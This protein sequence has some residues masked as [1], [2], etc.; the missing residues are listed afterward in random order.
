MTKTVPLNSLPNIKL[1][2]DE[3]KIFQVL[4][5]KKNCYYKKLDQKYN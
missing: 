3:L 4:R 1:E 5:K 2:Q